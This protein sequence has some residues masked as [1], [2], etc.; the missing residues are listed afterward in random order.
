MDHKYC[1]WPHAKVASKFRTTVVIMMLGESSEFMN[2][3][4]LYE[5]MKIEWTSNNKKINR[6]TPANQ[7]R[8]CLKIQRGGFLLVLVEKNNQ[9]RLKYLCSYSMVATYLKRSV[10]AIIKVK[11][12]LINVLMHCKSLKFIL[13]Q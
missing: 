5:T 4:N 1:S 6:T 7:W 11:T 12:S 10:Q 9:I 3:K 13:K 2:I 8:P